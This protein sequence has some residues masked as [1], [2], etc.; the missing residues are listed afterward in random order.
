[1]IFCERWQTLREQGKKPTADDLCARSPKLTA[2]LREQ[3]QAVA[4][5]MSLLGLD[6]ESNP[7]GSIATA[8]SLQV[9]SAATV[10]T[11]RSG[12]AADRG[13]RDTKTV[14]QSTLEGQHG[15]PA[16]ESDGVLKS[17]R[18]PGYE[19]LEELGRGGMGV[20]YKAR[21]RSLD[22]IVALKMILAA[23]HAGST[24]TARFLHEAKT[25][26]SLKHTH[27]VQV[28]EFGTH[29][30]R[31]FFSLEYLEGGSLAEKLRGEPQAPAQAAKMV[32]TLAQAVQAAH[33][34][35][36]V[37]RDLKPAN[38]LLTADGIPKISDFGI[39]KQSD[40]IMTATGEVLGTPSYMSPEQAAGKTKLVGAPAD[41]YALGAILYELLT[42]R[43]PFKGASAWETIQLVTQSDPVAPCQLQPRVPLDLET[44]CLK[45]LE[46]EPAKRYARA[47]DV[48]R[49]LGHFLAGEPIHARPVGKMER[50]GRWCLRNKAVAASSA[51]VALSLIAATVVSVLFWIRAE[52]ARRVEADRARSEASARQDAVQA[53]RGVQQQLID[54]STEA[55]LAA[56]REEDH[57]LA[58]LWFARTAQLS[59]GY[60]EREE[61][62]RTRYA[63]WLRQVWTP[64]GTTMIPGFR[65]GQDR[66]RQLTFSPD[67]NYLVATASV[68]D[69]LLWDR[70][71]GRLV[72][73]TG[74]AAGAAAWE[75]TSGLLALGSR[76]GTIRLLAPPAFTPV[77]ELPADGDVAVLAF[78][79]DGRRLAWGG[80]KGAR[81]WDRETKR[82]STPLL[83]HGG[84]V[85]TLAFSA[86][87]ALLATSARDMKARVFRVASEQADPVFPPV[88]HAL[89]EYAINH[90]GPERVAPRFAAADRVLLTVERSGTVYNLCWRSA[91]SGEV[92]TTTDTEVGKEHLGA[93]DVTPDGS[94]V[95]V[96]WAGGSIRLCDAATRRIVAAIP[97]GPMDWCEDL[98]FSADGQVAVTCSQDTKVQ[99][100]SMN[101][102]RN[103]ELTRA[104]P[105]L[106]HP[107]QAVRVD[108]SK[109]RRHLA[110]ALWDG[111]ICLWRGP[112]GPPKAY[113]IE[114]GGATW[115]ALSPNRRL[116]LPK[117]ASFRGGSLRNTRV[118]D[119]TNG[120][121]VGPLLS[122]GGI[123]VDAAFSPEGEHLAMA[124]LTAQTPDERDTRVFLADG[125][126]GYVQLWDWK[127]GRKLVGPIPMPA[128]PR[129]L[130]FRPDG[131][132]LAVVCADYRVLLVDPRS[133]A[134]LR[135]LDPGIRTK[136][137]NA[138]L[139]TSN[140]DAR[141][142]PDGRF[143][144]TWERVPTLHV[145]D[146]DSG[147]LLHTLK[148]TE[149]VENAAFSP[150]APHILATG[151]RDSTI[152]V[153]DLDQGKLLVQLQQPRWTQMLQFSPDGSELISGCLDGIIRSWNWRTG[154]LSRGLAHDPAQLC[155]AFTADRRTLAV[156][157]L[158]HWKLRT[159]PAAHHSR[160][161]RPSATRFTGAWPF[162]PATV[163]RSSPGSPAW[164]SAS[165]WRKC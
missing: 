160:P 14:L 15:E 24:A 20:V 35:G 86:D 97:S 116:M 28:Y 109:D 73:L 39:A 117:G 41:I 146:P 64:E 45:C 161:S 71:A 69:C 87:G 96:A 30:G 108:L 56:A 150:S 62:S 123:I 50:A 107:Q 155:F 111:T 29:E 157:A 79:R 93:F 95:A 22:R 42:G 17:V 141:F 66:F 4:S 85:V 61:L 12:G 118:Y 101:V 127:D 104:A 44:I 55:G 75:P 72:P 147:R 33:E 140:G 2:E 92:L 115:L 112:D 139:W 48:A 18:V 54:L 154:A 164:S 119:A 113:E 26:A 148:H 10:E 114:A 159:G 82:Y 103:L 32:Q 68:G 34:Q 83:K 153:W 132:T 84:P 81:I 105:P 89:A 91:A 59:S 98:V 25:I 120:E 38:V 6:E 88:P 67:G 49:D 165:T 1:M 94:R 57:A 138:N 23:S 31:P 37:H 135:N 27:V 8:D 158:T 137:F 76:D 5:M 46:K 136:P 80:A 43:P 152:R 51:A 149:R 121:P 162:P 142:S 13:S 122:P 19:V 63:N 90:G 9:R 3:L 74:P 58:L 102:E 163:G 151:G 21:Q 131:R 130:A 78:S 36:I 125:K 133:G 47:T 124:A 52:Q 145:W 16:V 128:E 143:L 99:L 11:D 40:S 144:L 129:G 100:W 156:Q 134:V 126:A 110:V 53:R 77:E 65:Q 60:P 106:V 70:P 7:V